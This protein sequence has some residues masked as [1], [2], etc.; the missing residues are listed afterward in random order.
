[1]KLNELVRSIPTWTSNEER[2]LLSKIND[3]RP[4]DSFQERDQVIIE[5]LIRKSL[6]IK[7]ASKDAVYVYPNQ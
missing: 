3:L 5:S 1:M 6:L 4:L 7:V 2:E